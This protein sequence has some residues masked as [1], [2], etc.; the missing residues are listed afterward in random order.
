MQS[1]GF[2]SAGYSFR[3]ASKAPLRRGAEFQFVGRLPGLP[4]GL[5]IVTSTP[6]GIE[7]CQSS[8]N[9]WSAV[10][11]SNQ[12]SRDRSSLVYPINRTAECLERAVRIELTLSDWKTDACTNRPGPQNHSEMDWIKHTGLFQEPANPFQC[13]D[14]FQS[15]C[16]SVH[17]VYQPVSCCDSATLNHL[18]GTLRFRGSK[19]QEVFSY[20]GCPVSPARLGPLMYLCGEGA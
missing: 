4:S 19:R 9:V 6:Q 15:A 17:A 20:S 8:R 3:P 2:I 14:C 10:L 16:M 1:V 12:Q 13:A 5:L 18:R 7:Y 11:D